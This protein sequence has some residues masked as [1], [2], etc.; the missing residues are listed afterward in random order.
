MYHVDLKW[1]FIGS[2]GMEVI[3]C[4]EYPIASFMYFKR[5]SNWCS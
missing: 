4:D 5:Q 1:Q 3:A 2:F